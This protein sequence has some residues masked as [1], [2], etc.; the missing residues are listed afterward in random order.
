MYQKASALNFQ[1]KKKS[2]ELHDLEKKES[3]I[4]YLWELSFSLEIHWSVKPRCVITV[5]I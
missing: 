5:L 4:P 2:R 3:E 1:G